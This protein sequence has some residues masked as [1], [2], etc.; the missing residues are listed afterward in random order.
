[1]VMKPVSEDSDALVLHS[2]GW[3]GQGGARRKRLAAN[4][5]GDDRDWA[6]D[7]A[8]AK[9]APK[10]SASCNVGHSSV[11]LDALCEGSRTYAHTHTHTHT[12]TGPVQWFICQRR[13]R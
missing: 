12:H 4:V 6:K 11:V 7:S 8:Q 3:K 1:M 2:H 13:R 9:L 10:G 5:A